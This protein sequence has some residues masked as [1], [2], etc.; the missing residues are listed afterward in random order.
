[1]IAAIIFAIHLVAATYAFAS[2]AKSGGISEGFLALAFMTIIF[3]VGWT[4]ATMTANL[5]FEPE[6]FAEWFNRDTI[7]LSLVT[8]GE[9][10]FYAL[11]LKTRMGTGQESDGFRPE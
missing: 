4:I 1:M 7:S 2:K 11:L 3:S 6:G 5:L 9:V 10:V 8:I